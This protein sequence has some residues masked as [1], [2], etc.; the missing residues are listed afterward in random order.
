MELDFARTLSAVET[1]LETLLHA[2]AELDRRIAGLRLAVQGLRQTQGLS[3][4]GPEREGLTGS[5]RAIL[6]SAAQPLSVIEIKEQ[7]D[8]IGFDWSRYSS[9]VSAL[10]TVL[11]RLAASGQ[12]VAAETGGKVRYCWKQVRVVVARK[13]DIDDPA[14]LDELV[15]QLRVASATRGSLKRKR[16]EKK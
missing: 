12:A 8:S 3:A 9:P 4:P 16:K 11:K 14:R 13:E 2:R 10:H 6:R 7:L 5:C 1:E 15:K